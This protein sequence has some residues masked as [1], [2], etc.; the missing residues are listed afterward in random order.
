MI[1]CNAIFS[2]GGSTSII[3]LIADLHG[4]ELFDQDSMQADAYIH[5][6]WYPAV[7]QLSIFA[8]MESSPFCFTV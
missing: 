1:D 2:A 4:R 5:H 8:N 3:R 7:P 6:T